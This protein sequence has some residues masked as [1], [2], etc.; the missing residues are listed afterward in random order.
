MQSLCLAESTQISADGKFI[1]GWVELT[2]QQ[3]TPPVLLCFSF[4][5][6]FPVNLRDAQEDVAAPMSQGQE[7]RSISGYMETPT[8]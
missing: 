5:F 1:Q 7:E 8:S 4:W 3:N 6:S 2:V